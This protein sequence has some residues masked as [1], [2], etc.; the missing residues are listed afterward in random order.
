MYCTGERRDSKISSLVI[1]LC[2]VQER[3]G[4]C[5]P[6]VEKASDKLLPVKPNEPINTAESLLS[7]LTSVE[8]DHAQHIEHNGT[9]VRTDS[10]VYSNSVTI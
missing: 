3:G 4:M 9:K 2:I 6:P 8:S 10:S 7:S 5:K 1:D